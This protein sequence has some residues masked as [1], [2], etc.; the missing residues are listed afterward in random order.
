MGTPVRSGSVIFISGPVT[1]IGQRKLNANPIR[2]FF[3]LHHLR[4]TGLCHS[5][6]S[7]RIRRQLRRAV[8]LRHRDQSGFRDASKPH[9]TLGRE[10]F[11][12]LSCSATRS[13]SFIPFQRAGF[14][15]TYSTA[16]TKTFARVDH[17]PG[18]TSATNFNPATTMFFVIPP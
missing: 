9:H 8:P 2:E 18:K 17:R 15:L 13:S 6:E 14:L 10:A 4:T 7:G 1:I 16:N 5:G 11:P 12:A 3:Y